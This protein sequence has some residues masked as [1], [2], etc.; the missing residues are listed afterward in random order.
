[1]ETLILMPNYEELYDTGKRHWIHRKLLPTIFATQTDKYPTVLL[2]L[3]FWLHRY[4]G[5]QELP[6]QQE[7]YYQI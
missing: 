4:A 2:A 1:M 7:L 6:Q 5:R 3:A